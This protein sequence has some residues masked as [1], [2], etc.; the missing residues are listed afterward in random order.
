LCALPG[1]VV[2]VVVVGV[3]VAVVLAV[4]DVVVVV[5][6]VVLGVVVD[7]CWPGQRQGG[8]E[9]VHGASMPEHLVGF[10]PLQ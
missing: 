6:A 10:L 5:V 2:E 7:G 8:V 3:V 4:V 1:V 9:H